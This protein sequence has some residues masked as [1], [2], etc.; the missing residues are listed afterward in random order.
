[1]PS[2]RLRLRHTRTRLPA[3]PRGRAGRH[4]GRI[5][6]H[7]WTIGVARRTRPKCLGSRSLDVIASGARL[8]ECP[9]HRTT[10]VLGGARGTAGSHC[11]ALSRGRSEVGRALP[12]L[13]QAKDETMPTNLAARRDSNLAAGAGHSD[14]TWKTTS[15]F[16]HTLARDIH[17][18]AEKSLPPKDR[19]H[20]R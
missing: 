6:S 1:M 17:D 9:S 18:P 3:P 5:S 11:P 15:R 8:C 20:A 12:G 2:G 19:D 10:A 4:S 16:G 14:P 13:P 7:R